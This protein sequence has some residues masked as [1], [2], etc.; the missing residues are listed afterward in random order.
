[1]PKRLDLT[2]Q[3][4]N[5]L[6]VIKLSDVVKSNRRAWECKCDCGN[7]TY[8]TSTELTKGEKKSCGCLGGVRFDLTGQKFNSLTVIKLSDV[9]RCGSY[10]WE[11][12]C[13]C[14]NITYALS[15][16]L[17]QGIKKSC[18]CLKSEK[19]DLVGKKF[20]NLVVIGLSDER[21]SDVKTW[22][23]RCKCGNLVLAR[24]GDLI[25]GAKTSCG[26][27]TPN[28]YNLIGETFDYLTV[29]EKIGTN[30]KRCIVWKCVCKCGNETTATTSELR[31]GHKKS[32][33]CLKNEPNAKD[34]KGRRFGK[35]KVLKWV[36]TSEDRKALWRCKCDCGKT[37]T[38]R[39]I[40]L[41]SGNTKSCGCYGK[42]YAKRNLEKGGYYNEW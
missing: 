10:A 27:Q 21:I 32:C 34:L 26:C 23:C 5:H 22:K 17:T 29:T 4:F 42:N 6:T 39:S 35:L 12:V 13:D 2:G 25:S 8:A 1:M 3:K 15:N 31:G 38:V 41:L 30:N 20:G 9:K 14:G 36:G 24:T 40:D 18:G 11:C 33:G 28:R 37:V 7:T 19:N 16:E